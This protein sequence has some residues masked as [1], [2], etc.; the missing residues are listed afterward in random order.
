MERDNRQS[1][2][3]TWARVTHF[4]E[5]QSPSSNAKL[6][7][8]CGPARGSSGLPCLSHYDVDIAC[9][10]HIKQTNVVK[11]SLASF[12]QKSPMAGTVGWKD[13]CWGCMGAFDRHCTSGPDQTPG[14]VYR[15]VPPLAKGD[16]ERETHTLMRADTAG[17]QRAAAQG[18]SWCLRLRD[19][20]VRNYIIRS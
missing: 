2:W 18:Q 12:P 8:T 11:P 17:P 4:R 3:G 20:C 15:S 16:L 14:T 19:G 6:V 7:L 10:T 1:P 9:I 13:A 5:N